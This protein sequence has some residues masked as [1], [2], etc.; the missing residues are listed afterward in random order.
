MRCAGVI[1]IRAALASGLAAAL[2]ACGGGQAPH[3][4]PSPTPTP[5]AEAQ[6]IDLYTVASPTC[7]V[8][9]E[10]QV[11]ERPISATVRIESG[12]TVVRSVTTDAT[13]HARVGLAPGTYTVAAQA[14]ST[15]MF[16]RPPMRET[17][18][19]PAG[20]GYVVVRLDY[21]TGIR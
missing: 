20:G 15:T 7:P 9:R 17:V 11:C 21:D 4:T 3:R 6:G 2:A 8:Q 19:V 14:A 16:P 10:G 18:T 13:G 12:G 1:A 5:P